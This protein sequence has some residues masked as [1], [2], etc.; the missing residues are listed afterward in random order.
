[1]AKGA[2]RMTERDLDLILLEEL[3]S[4]TGFAGWI[5]NHIG[6]P[7]AVLVSAEHSVT[8]K[9]NARWGETDVLAHFQTGAERIAVLIEDKIAAQFADRQAVRYHE[10]ARELVASGLSDRTVVVLC[11]PQAYLADVPRDDPWDRMISLEDL[12]GWF[13]THRD[14]RG[15]WRARAL[16]ACLLRLART[17]SAGSDDIR[18]FSAALK[19]YLVDLDEGFDHNVTGDPWGFIL[20]STETPACVQLAWKNN[21]GRVDLSFWDRHFGKA[22]LVTPPDGI[23]ILRGDGIKV[24]TDI[25]GIDVPTADVTLPFESQTDV[26]REVMNAARALLPIVP[27][28]L[29]AQR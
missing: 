23:S 5:A 2:F 9:A 29:A 19:A 6:L 16:R 26:V 1:M 28:V 3:C 17:R 15:E 20:K 24:K 4:D 21:K 12:A 13:E 27:E 8:A 18:R 25:F 14:F 7:K 22:A 10:R 11:A